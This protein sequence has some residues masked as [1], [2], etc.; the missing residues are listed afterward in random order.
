MNAADA[1]VS[2]HAIDTL[3]NYEA[4]KYF[5]NEE[6]ESR[7]YDELLGDYQ[8]EAVEVQRT[9]GVLN[10]G[11]QGIFAVGLS[12]I[13][14]LTSSDIAA[15]HATVGDLVLVN[16]LLFQLA[17]PLHFIGMVYREI[18]QAL[19]DMENMFDLL[20]KP[21]GPVPASY[22][23]VADGRARFITGY[24]VDPPAEPPTI[25]FEDVEFSRV[26]RADVSL[27]HRGDAG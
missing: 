10:F 24:G 13:M 25:R 22:K 19:V 12:A 2:G 18:N 1:A 9:L 5:G 16:G 4:V 7:R 23:Q 27:I 26:R 20:E 14:L 8:K 3:V 17:I 11:Q 21:P 6:H 15:G